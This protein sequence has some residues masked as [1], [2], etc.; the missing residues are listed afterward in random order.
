V[1]T[2]EQI[3]DRLLARF[4]GVA[5]TIVAN[6]GPAAQH[7]LLLGATH[8]REIA[9]FLRDDP[10]LKFD[11]CSNV[12]GVDWPEKEIVETTKISVPDPANPSAPPKIVEQKTKR[13]EPGYLEVV[14]HLYS[15][16]LRHGPVVLRLRTGNR[17]AAVTVPSL[18]PVWRA[19]E[20]QER[21]VFDLYGV[22]FAGHPDLR[23][24]LM[25]DGFKDH[26]MRKDYVE[27]DDYE[28]EPTP[29][30]AVLEK[31][32]QHYPAQPAVAPAPPAAN[33]QGPRSND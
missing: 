18:T 19:C 5:I 33:T 26:P 10:A 14:Y 8:A 11:Q 12:T 9:T 25:W 17:T 29:H 27:P 21:E 28:W 31:A 20:F 23:R 16:A 13:L 30:G 22:A 1:E 2:P 24:I 4:P 7:S 3:R 15:I 6:P 32:R